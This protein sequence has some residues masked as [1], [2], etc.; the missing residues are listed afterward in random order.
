MGA[1]PMHYLGN[2]RLQAAAR[3]LEGQS[4]SIA[5]AAAEAGYESEAAFNRAFK[6]Q[7]GLPPGAWRRRRVDSIRA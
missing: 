4:M 5:Q 2:W 6:R 7:V 3:L 1:L